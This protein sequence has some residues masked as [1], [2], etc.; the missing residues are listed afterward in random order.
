[1][2]TMAQRLLCNAPN[3]SCVT[4]QWPTGTW[5]NP[6]SIPRT[7]GPHSSDSRPRASRGQRSSTPLAATALARLTEQQLRDLIGILGSA[8]EPKTTGTGLGPGQLRAP[9]SNT[10]W[11]CGPAER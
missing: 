1:M 8:L 5:S 2:K 3:L 6:A 11:T 7:A 10:R 4:T 9:R